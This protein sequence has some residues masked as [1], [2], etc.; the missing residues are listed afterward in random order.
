LP[1]V[2]FTALRLGLALATLR[3]VAFPRPDMDI[4][5]VLPFAAAPFLS[6]TFGRFFRLAMIVHF[7]LVSAVLSYG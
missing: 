7:R 6:C 2:F 4:L 5:R 3:F 1:A